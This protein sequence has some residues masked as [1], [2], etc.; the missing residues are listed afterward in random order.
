MDLTQIAMRMPGV[1]VD[2]KYVELRLP[3]TFRE[4]CANPRLTN[5]QVGRIIRCIALDTECFMTQETEPE[6]FF[7]RQDQKKRLNARLRKAKSRRKL[8]QPG[9]GAPENADSPAQS[10]VRLTRD[11]AEASFPGPAESG[12]A[13]TE[14]GPEPVECKPPAASAPVQP[15]PVQ[16]PPA[17]RRRTKAEKARDDLSGDLFA[18]VCGK[19]GTPS[20]KTRADAVPARD[21]RNDA[22]WI[23]GKFGEFWEQYPR[24]VA[25]SDAMKAFAKIVKAQPDVDKFMSVTMA[26]LAYWKSQDQ[27]TKANCTFIPYPASW[28]NAG[29]W[30]DC[31]E[32]V[33]RNPGQAT[34]LQGSEESDE[35]L[36]KRMRGETNA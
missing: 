25:K 11:D 4:L 31:A 36:F 2:L 18:V 33:D 28:L 21:T 17:R 26:S 13:R 22:A 8:G 23:P 9:K 16:S 6:I 12:P 27:W 34:F 10:D 24:K 15:P 29:H 30:N 19:P 7:Y 35:D 1:P 14:Q 20:D 3:G 32:D 5:E